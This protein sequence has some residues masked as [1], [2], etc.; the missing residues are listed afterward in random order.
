MVSESFNHLEVKMTIVGERWSAA[1]V[2]WVAISPELLA[3]RGLP[4]L[5]E[6]DPPASLP[7]STPTYNMHYPSIQ[8]GFSLGKFKTSQQ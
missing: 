7:D 5:L 2:S 4:L 6:I 1:T 8:T 3:E